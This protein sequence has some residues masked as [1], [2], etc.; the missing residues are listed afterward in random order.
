MNH[1]IFIFPTMTGTPRF[2]RLF[3]NVSNGD[4]LKFCLSCTRVNGTYEHIFALLFTSD[5]K[6]SLTACRRF[7]WEEKIY[8]QFPR[9]AMAN[10][11][12][13][14]NPPEKKTPSAPVVSKRPP[15]GG[16]GWCVVFGSFMIHVVSEWFII[17]LRI[18]F[19]ATF[20]K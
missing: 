12:R 2:I 18:I 13:S 6:I 15:D 20:N 16:W 7:Y 10:K 1:F 11:M 5:D 3:K 4:G 8:D 9:E 19:L 17:I 14:K